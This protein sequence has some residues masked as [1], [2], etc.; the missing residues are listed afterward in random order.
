MDKEKKGEE[1][2]VKNKVRITLT[3]KKVKL[4]ER[5]SGELI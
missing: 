3:G 5:V 1:E 4:V 2:G